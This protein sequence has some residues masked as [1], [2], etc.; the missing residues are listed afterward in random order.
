MKK[1]FVIYTGSSPKGGMSKYLKLLFAN[2]PEGGLQLVSVR[3]WETAKAIEQAG[4]TVA[5]VRGLLHLIRLAIAERPRALVTLGVKSTLFG[6]LA[7]LISGAQVITTVHSDFS[8]DYPSGPIKTVFWILDRLLRFKSKKFLAVSDYLKNRLIATGIPKEKIIVIHNGVEFEPRP[9]KHSASADEIVLGSV[10][11]MHPTKGFDLLIEALK[12]LP[13][14]YKLKIWG[15]GSE[16][17][18]LKQLAKKLGVEER[19]T[20]MGSFKEFSAVS[21]QIDIYVQSSRMEGFGLTLV[22]AMGAGLPVVVT[23]VGSL[24]EIVQNGKNGLVAES[25]DP[26]DIASKIKEISQPDLGANLATE[27]TKVREDYSVS[28]WIK[29]LIK[30]LA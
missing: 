7:G 3:R 13:A 20:F 10:G 28:R 16:K 5:Y 19:V 26:K 22:E 27:A 6:R 2:F 15:E 21:S 9:T 1:I 8:H 12:E 30:S 29:A 4:G 11:R 18:T 17:D 14:K 23:P 24:L 25:L